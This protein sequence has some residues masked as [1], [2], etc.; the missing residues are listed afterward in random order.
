MTWKEKWI[1]FCTLTRREVWRVFLVWLHAIL[2]PAITMTLYFI[3]FG[4]FVGR[5]ITNIHGFTYMQ[6]IA[7]GL[8]IMPAITAAYSN[9]ATSVYMAKFQRSIEEIL[10]SPMPN[11][12][13]LYGFLMGS[14]FRAFLM[15]IITMIVALFFTHLHVFSFMLL[16]LTVFLSTIFF[17][18][19]GFTNGLFARKFD[20]VSFVPV[21]ILNPLT[22]LGGVF[23]SVQ[24]LPSLWYHISLFNPVLYIVDAFR[25][26]MLGFAN[27]NIIIAF[28]VMFG[29]TILMFILNLYL[30]KKGSGIRQ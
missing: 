11:Q 20:E 17:G 14:L 29:L 23:Y 1:A 27:T 30:L 2:P 26:G 22:Y 18:L 19:I 8:I 25:Y 12:I 6:Y 7:P 16:F 15:T 4:E 28:L 13:I 9:T 21:F 10:V 5:H 24:S 3:I